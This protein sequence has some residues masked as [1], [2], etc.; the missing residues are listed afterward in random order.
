MPCHPG[1]TSNTGRSGGCAIAVCDRL[2]RST[3]R[4]GTRKNTTSQANGKPSTSLCAGGLLVDPPAA[5]VMVSPR[6][7]DRR[8][9]RERQPDLVAKSDG[10]FAAG[11]GIGDGGPDLRAVGNA[12]LVDPQL[13][14]IAD[15]VDRSGETVLGLGRRP[16]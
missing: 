12:Q 9:G 4:N 14:E 11:S 10:A 8:M 5:S 6:Q 16:L 2:I 15:L 3:I 1:V 13:A 7:Q